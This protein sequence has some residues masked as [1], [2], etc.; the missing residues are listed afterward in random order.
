MES[1]ADAGEEGAPAASARRA[2][3]VLAA[4]VPVL[5]AVARGLCRDPAAADDLV[6]DTLERA[7]RSIATLDLEHNPR[8]WLV[9]ILYNLHIDRCRQRARA[10]PHIPCDDLPLVAPDPDVPRWS[11]LT[12]D[13]VLRA[14][15]RLPDELR[16]VYLLFAFE[17]RS[18]VEISAALRIPKSTVGTRVLR[19]RAHLKRLLFADLD[20]EE[21]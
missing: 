9:A 13:D 5:F 4:Y 1:R 6:Q 21:S 3:D 12:A 7:L 11:T 14:A 15:Q 18:Y 17:R 10:Q 19:A 2:R 20:E 8:S 16:A